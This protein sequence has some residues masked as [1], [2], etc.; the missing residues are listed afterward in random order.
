[1]NRETL[2]KNEIL[3]GRGVFNELFE[4][5]EKIRGRVITLFVLPSENSQ[6]GIAVSKKYRR[7]VDRNRMRRLLREIYRKNKVW[8]Q[9]KKVVFYVPYSETIPSY[10]EFY[11]DVLNLKRFLEKC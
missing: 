7:A 5:G 4:R 1:M 6:M 11:E 8:F 9:K 3:R 10:R 2:S